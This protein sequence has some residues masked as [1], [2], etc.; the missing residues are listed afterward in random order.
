[1]YSGYAPESSPDALK[2][3]LK[4][5]RRSALEIISNSRRNLARVTSNRIRATA[6]SMC[7]AFGVRPV[8]RSEKHRKKRFVFQPLHCLPACFSLEECYGEKTAR[9]R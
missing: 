1:L 8:R 6:F 3:P 9:P 4:K 2:T 7:F 5:K